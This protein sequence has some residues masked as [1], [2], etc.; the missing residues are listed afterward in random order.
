MREALCA[1]IKD[2]KYRHLILKSLSEDSMISSEI[3]KKLGT[4]RSSTSRILRALKGKGLVGSAKS[5][6]RTILYS[7]TKTGADLLRA[8]KQ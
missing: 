7:L 1:W 4:H 6:S 8:V 2:G 3:A 5:G